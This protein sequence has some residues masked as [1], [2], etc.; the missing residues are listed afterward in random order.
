MPAS[1]AHR[2]DDPERLRFLP[3]DAVLNRL[4]L[5][6]G[7]VVADVGAGTGYFSLPIARAIGIGGKLFAVDVQ[8]E[9]L[10][11]LQQ[12][13]GRPDTPSNIVLVH[14]EAKTTTLDDHSCDLVFL[15]NVWHE[16]PDHA[17]ALMEIRRILKPGGTLA[18]VDWRPDTEHPPG[19][20]VEH[21]ISADN[22]CRDLESH[23]FECDAP[24]KVG[25][26]SYMALAK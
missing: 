24:F 8:H 26:Y 9:M 25:Q 20:P 10:E 19:P 3:P 2:L 16:L 11:L 5:K 22:V 1:N 23:G 4:P 15:A 21:R 13:L 7:I 6:P 18:I 14:G 12:K 17:A